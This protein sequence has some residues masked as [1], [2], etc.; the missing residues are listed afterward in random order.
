MNYVQ[1]RKEVV[2]T[3]SVKSRLKLVSFSMLDLHKQNHI[4]SLRS[5][6]SLQSCFD[7]L[8]PYLRPAFNTHCDKTAVI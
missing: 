1:L 6:R 5:L 8:S 7:D 3:F 2:N 4:G